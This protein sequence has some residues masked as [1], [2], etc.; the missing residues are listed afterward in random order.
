MANWCRLLVQEIR[1]A[2]SLA[3]VNAGSSSAA[4]IAMM[5]ITT[6]SSISVNALRSDRVINVL[7]M[8]VDLAGI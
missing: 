2:L 8:F 1:L 5:A 7:F 6:N 3:L 4:K